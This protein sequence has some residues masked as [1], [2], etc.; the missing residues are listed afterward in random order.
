MAVQARQVTRVGVPTR[1]SNQFGGV[2]YPANTAALASGVVVAGGTSAAQQKT[3]AP[4]TGQELTF[5]LSSGA[6]SEG[7]HLSDDTVYYTNP[8]I[9]GASA[10]AVA[11]VSPKG[12]LTA[13]NNV[14]STPVYGS[15]GGKNTYLG[16]IQYV[17]SVS[18]TNIGFAYSGFTGASVSE[19]TKVYVPDYSAGEYV[20]VGITLSGTAAYNRGTGQ[21][22][23]NFP[24]FYGPGTAPLPPSTLFLT[25]QVVSGSKFGLPASVGVAYNVQVS[26]T[27]TG[28][29]TS[30]TTTG[31]TA[32]NAVGSKISPTVGVTSTTPY[33]TS[34][35]IYEATSSGITASTSVATNE[36]VFSTST[37]LIG[38]TAGGNTAYL[39]PDYGI[40]AYY[41]KLL[42]VT[43]T[44]PASEAA[45]GTG[46]TNQNGL[47]GGN[48]VPSGGAFIPVGGSPLTGISTFENKASVGGKTYNVN[49]GSTLNTGS[50]SSPSPV[51]PQASS[52]RATATT[53]TDSTLDTTSQAPS[54]GWKVSLSGTTHQA[55]PVSSS[56]LSIG[57][58]TSKSLSPASG[59]YTHVSSPNP[60][61]TAIAMFEAQ[62]YTQS[63]AK[64]VVTLQGYE[65]TVQSVKNALGATIGQI[66]LVGYGNIES[67][68]ESMQGGLSTLYYGNGS[69]SA[70]LVAVGQI[71]APSA[72]GL[73]EGVSL[74]KTAALGVSALAGT[75]SYVKVLQPA[76]LAAGSIAM[77]IAAGQTSPKQIT[78]NA[79]SGLTFYGTS[80]IILGG[81]SSVTTAA[82][83]IVGKVVATDASQ[84]FAYGSAGV[85]LGEVQSVATT[86]RGLTALQEVGIFIASA[87]FTVGGNAVSTQIFGETPASIAINSV[88]R[89]GY[90]ESLGSGEV[91]L[92]RPVSLNQQVS[93]M[94]A[95]QVTFVSQPDQS[96]TIAGKNYQLVFS[97][98]GTPQYAFN[99][100]SSDYDVQGAYRNIITAI[101]T[102]RMGIFTGGPDQ[103]YYTAVT[104]KGQN[105]IY[106]YSGTATGT[107]DLGTG[108]SVQ[109]SGRQPVTMTSEGLQAEGASSQATATVTLKSAFREFLN[110]YFGVGLPTKTFDISTTLSPSLTTA[111]A[112]TNGEQNVATLLTGEGG[113]TTQETY[114]GQ[115]VSKI[116]IQNSDYVLLSGKTTAGPRTIDLTD[117]LYDSELGGPKSSGV[118]IEAPSG[119]STITGSD[120]SMKPSEYF[121]AASPSSSAAEPGSVAGVSPSGTTTVVAKPAMAPPAQLTDLQ[122]PASTT[123]TE[124]M[125]PPDPSVI[126]TSVG[127]GA[128]SAQAPAPPAGAGPTT[129]PGAQLSSASPG[130]PA[131]QTSSL[132]TASSF[133]SPSSYFSAGKGS[134][135]SA[136]AGKSLSLSSLLTGSLGSEQSTSTQPVYRQVNVGP[137]QSPPISNTIPTLAVVPEEAFKGKKSSLSSGQTRSLSKSYLETGLSARLAT[138]NSTASEFGY[139]TAFRPATATGFKPAFSQGY[140]SQ[141]SY[142]SASSSR[143][144]AVQRTQNNSSPGS[145]SFFNFNTGFGSQAFNPG[146]RKMPSKKH[147]QTNFTAFRPAFKYNVDLTSQTF[148]IRG[149][150][151]SKRGHEAIGLARPYF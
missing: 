1:L 133:L 15:V 136:S 121:P 62:G 101:N 53:A 61:L 32:Y 8:N 31:L 134:V 43:T 33:G 137:F 129:A 14:I 125:A 21:V 113:T 151:G 13:T 67:G 25:P 27:A 117:V 17:P 24:G 130:R 26:P 102:E 110:E 79:V 30:V 38:F 28:I 96:F 114:A 74:G 116:D 87:V 70:K 36:T 7:F 128:L 73:V 148:H 35:T 54:L 115:A 122:L 103:Q 6:M 123:T 5:S 138:G 44:P 48:V 42:G 50:V 58:F 37:G 126:A 51:Q 97:S 3:S 18:G 120:L 66:P 119:P 56:Y 131:L 60:S 20:P 99:P 65:N 98:S 23:V 80:E 11:T 106:T 76:I 81:T 150:K 22:T 92:N 135:S 112:G 149:A 68:S 16:T 75:G 104:L 139:R 4:A 145:A 132:S 90:Y 78:Y 40:G 72:L 91:T 105:F 12:T 100:T 52:P 147:A 29:N 127:S 59:D 94:G 71:V 124:L 77:G 93:S 10:V 143:N 64:E 108:A 47:I 89:Q 19:T 118:K 88:D 82:S 83:E 41:A 46:A 95:Q 85:L 57:T 107:T 144:Q 63:Q 111:I 140:K 55:I 84:T 34:T 2:T 141:V 9:Q 146:S 69:T 39:S 45:V 86:G 49:F 109:F 142:K